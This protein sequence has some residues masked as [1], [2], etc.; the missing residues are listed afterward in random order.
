MVQYTTHTDTGRD[1]RTRVR[2]RDDVRYEKSRKNPHPR[3]M[4]TLSGLHT[5]VAHRLCTTFLS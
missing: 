1:T 2:D 3:S 5:D 4:H